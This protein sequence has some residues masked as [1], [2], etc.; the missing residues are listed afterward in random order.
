MNTT[1][2]DKRRH[3]KGVPYN[4]FPTMAYIPCNESSCPNKFHRSQE[5]ATRAHKKMNNTKNLSSGK[6]SDVTND[7]A[8]PHTDIQHDTNTVSQRSEDEI[9]SYCEQYLDHQE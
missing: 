8:Y 6:L 7:F 9:Y 2:I 4:E 1:I 5:A 3:T